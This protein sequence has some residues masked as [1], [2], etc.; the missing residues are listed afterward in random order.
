MGID[1]LRPAQRPDQRQLP[2][3]VGQMVVPANDVGHAH[4]MVVHHHRQHVGRRSVRSQQHE[5]VE[6]G[7]GLAH[8]PLHPV[9]DHRLA[10]PRRFQPHHERQIGGVAAP[11]REFDARIAIP[12][13]PVIA[14]RQPVGLLR[15][16]HRLQFL[17]GR[18]AAIGLA[19]GQQSVRDFGMARRPRKLEQGRPVGAQPQPVHPVEDLRNRILGRS[20]PVRVL[21]PQQ[22]GA[23]MVPRIQPVE[24]RRACAPDVQIAGGGGGKAGHGPWQAGKIGQDGIACVLHL[25]VRSC[26]RYRPLW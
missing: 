12:P 3:R 10:I 25:G 17:L 16:P 14:L 2:E 24:Q 15:L 4:V 8:P 19:V 21:D 20:R 6:L 11:V 9:L 13:A 23:P 22:E 7:I 18:K 26:S 1:R 5:I